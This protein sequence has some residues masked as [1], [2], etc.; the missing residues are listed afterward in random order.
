MWVLI[1][2]LVIFG[3]ALY[4]FTYINRRNK[5]EETEITIND[6][7]E[8]CGA[9]EVCDKDSLLSS[10]NKIEYFDDEELDELACISPEN[11]TEQQ[12]NQLAEVFYTLKENEVA[13]WL[14]SIQKRQIILPVSIREEALL[15]ISERRN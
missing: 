1:I 5:N 15:I 14:K 10:D 7:G 8:C 6:D 13:P 3:L 9:H 2:I 12:L 11:Y 4:V